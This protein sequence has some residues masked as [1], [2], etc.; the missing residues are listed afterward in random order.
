MATWLKAIL[1]RDSI[2]SHWLDLAASPTIIY[3]KGA[4]LPVQGQEE[5]A[6]L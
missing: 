1:C 4:P 3:L 2:S 6:A 5:A